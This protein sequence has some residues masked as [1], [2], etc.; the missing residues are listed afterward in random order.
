MG[1][2][3]ESLSA[4]LALGGYPTFLAYIAF[5]CL[6]VGAVGKKMPAGIR[7][8]RAKP[9]KVEKYGE[10]K[11]CKE[12]LDEFRGAVGEKAFFGGDSPAATDISL[13]ATF[14]AFETVPYTTR[15]LRECGLGEWY[16]RV[17]SKMP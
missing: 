13:Y 7:H 9:E 10:L 12:Y 17:E 8:R 1:E 2:D 5:P 11:T 4:F 14:K 15:I 16:S 6:P 3:G